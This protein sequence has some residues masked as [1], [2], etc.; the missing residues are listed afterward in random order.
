VTRRIVVHTGFHKT[1]TTSAQAF[2]AENGPVLWPVMA[3]GLGYKF[4]PLL[5]AARG[6]STWRDPFSLE[7]F[8]RRFETYLAELNLG[9]RDLLI[10]AEEL[11][12]HLP[13]RGDLADYSAA[14]ILMQEIEDVL[15]AAYPEAAVTFVLTLRRPETW[16][17]SAYWEHVKS[18]RMVLDYAAFLDTYGALDLADAAAAI[19]LRSDLRTYWL[20]EMSQTAHGP[21][22]PLL[23]LMALSEERWAK[24][25]PIVEK[26]RAPRAREALI[27]DF[28]TLN[29]SA[30]DQDALKAAKKALLDAAETS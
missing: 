28:L 3:L 12:G 19:D 2:L 8:R 13:G 11:S 24:L 25:T 26:N 29:R 14:P 6:F 20:E 30:L 22:T 7:K 17:P 4:R 27:E 10:S 16:W 5:S 18:S 21:A 1:G 15:L 9:K 23:R